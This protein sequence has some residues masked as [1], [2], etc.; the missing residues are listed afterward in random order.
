MPSPNNPISLLATLLC[1]TACNETVPEK[2]DIYTPV[3]LSMNDVSVLYP[4]P[5]PEDPTQ[6]RASDVGA[7][8]E[9]FPEDLSDQIPTFGAT[10]D[11]M[12]VYSM[13]R[14]VSLRFDACGGMPESCR[15]EIRLVMQPISRDGRARD[16]A[17]HL[18]YYIDDFAE[19]VATLRELRALEPETAVSA[20]LDVH[21][22]LVAQGVDGAYGAALRERV[23]ELTGVDRL[24]RITF[25][26]RAPSTTPNW[27]MG[28]FEVVDGE[29]STLKIEGVRDDV[30]Q[31][32][33]DAAG[34][35]Y[36][37]QIS[38]AGISVEDGSDFL[39]SEAMAAAT[40]T[41]RAEAFASYL[42]VENPKVYV[43]DQL[44]CVG[45]HLSTFVTGVAEREYGLMASAFPDDGYVSATRDLQLRSGAANNPTSLRA[46]GWFDFD[47]MI[48]RRTVNDTAQ[49]LDTIEADY[50]DLR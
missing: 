18:F 30:Q 11:D 40:D 25:F 37:Y 32:I 9:L 45:C 46:L 15:P 47:P 22:S 21:P 13:L 1:I 8:G 35:S 43:P 5:D 39:S 49:V 23:L 31:V 3:L 24:H 2:P 20:P 44:S 48:S 50:P 10:S 19:T 29:T 28:G 6:L 34:E 7:Y 33:L 16:T 41:Q 42:R 4:L 26:L 27:F 38:P 12:L 17:L 14:V 36:N